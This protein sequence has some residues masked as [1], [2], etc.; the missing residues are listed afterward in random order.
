MESAG[1]IDIEWYQRGAITRLGE[2]FDRSFVLGRT[3]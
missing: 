1:F 2:S 3:P